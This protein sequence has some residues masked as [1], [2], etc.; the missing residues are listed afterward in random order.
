MMSCSHIVKVAELETFFLADSYTLGLSRVFA[1]PFFPHEFVDFK[2]Y[3]WAFSPH[4]F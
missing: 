2:T 4:I 3:N 1:D